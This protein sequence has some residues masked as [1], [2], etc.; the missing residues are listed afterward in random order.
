VIAHPTGRCRAHLSRSEIGAK[1]DLGVTLDLDKCRAART[2]MTA[3][4][5]SCGEARSA[6]LN[7]LKARERKPRAE[8]I[9]RKWGDSSCAVGRAI[10]RPT[11]RFHRA[12]L[13]AEDVDLPIKELGAEAPVYDRPHVVLAEAC[14]VKAADVTPPMSTS[15][16][17]SRLIGSSRPVSKRL[18][19]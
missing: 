16:R 2:V 4:D 18:G 3:Y 11:K 14:V 17:C 12:P 5:M 8:A 19:L 9:F 7:V 1:G 13:A 10:P 15:R 6:M